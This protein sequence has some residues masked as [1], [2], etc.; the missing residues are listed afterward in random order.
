M[1]VTRGYR[2][3]KEVCSNGYT[4]A[5]SGIIEVR[6]TD[7]HSQMK[8]AGYSNSLC[9]VIQNDPGKDALRCV[10]EITRS[11]PSSFSRNYVNCVK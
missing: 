7:V 9:S 5:I 8:E 4:W 11:C 1:G 6:G 10:S 3:S 2:S